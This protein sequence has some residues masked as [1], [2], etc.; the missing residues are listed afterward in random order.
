MADDLDVSW[1]HP[2][3]L[4]S[5]DQNKCR[6]VW[7]QKKRKMMK[8]PSARVVGLYT[9]S[10]Q[11]A[12]DWYALKPAAAINSFIEAEKITHVPRFKARFKN[13]A[14]HILCVL[15]HSCDGFHAMYVNWR[16]ML[17]MPVKR[18]AAGK[19]KSTT[20]AMVTALVPIRDVIAQSTVHKCVSKLT[21]IYPAD[22][23]TV[24]GM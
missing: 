3:Y 15:V 20:E 7:W 14:C 11:Q 24:A 22:F 12:S 8:S 21:T 16:K 9:I 19:F 2:W 13:R 18:Y 23:F 5:D 17:P 10:I 6:I 1:D 4:V